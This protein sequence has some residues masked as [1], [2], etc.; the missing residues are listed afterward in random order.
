MSCGAVDIETPRWFQV[1]LILFANL[2]A[3]HTATE[4][5]P[6]SPD[7]A[8][9]TDATPLTQ[10]GQGIYVSKPPRAAANA[11]DP[12]LPPPNQAIPQVTV[13]ELPF[14]RL[15]P[16]ELQLTQVHQQLRRSRGYRPLMHLAWRQPALNRN[17]AVSVV[18]RSPNA[19]ALTVS[20]AALAEPIEDRDRAN[21]ATPTTL[22]RMQRFR[23][24]TA[25]AVTEVAPWEGTARLWVAR[26]LHLDV[27]LVYRRL[28]KV[29][30]HQGNTPA[31]TGTDELP[32]TGPAPA[33]VREV[34]QEF[35]M[36]QTRR[37]RSR[38]LHFFDH[39]AFGLLVSVVPYTPPVEE[40][41]PDATTMPAPT[42]P[43]DYTSEA[44]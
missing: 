14:V 1:E 16:E 4:T 2:L 7:S 22:Q 35:R 15:P 18:I 10:S 44:G 41:P 12:T 42:R 30:V 39:P 32:A 31:T 5:W 29:E 6:R 25:S 3:A 43:A 28:G 36:Q 9:A 37:M 8:D 33:T 11:A 17:D 27:D 40:P 19:K 13:L 26:Y 21:E 23:T 24:D 34:L 20:P 38:E